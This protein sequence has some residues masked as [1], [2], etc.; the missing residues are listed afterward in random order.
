MK[1]DEALR[2]LELSAESSYSDA[3]KAYKELI[4]VWHSDRYQHSAHLL[5]RAKEKTRLLNEAWEVISAE[6]EEKFDNRRRSKAAAEQ[7]KHPYSPRG[8]SPNRTGPIKL[9]N[10][11]SSGVMMVPIWKN[12]PLLSRR[13]VSVLLCALG[14]LGYGCYRF[15]DLLEEVQ[16]LLSG[17]S[18][19]A[20][21]EQCGAG[22]KGSRLRVIDG[23]LV[24]DL[25]D[26][27]LR[28]TLSKDDK[29]ITA[30]P[31]QIAA[32][33]L[34]SDIEVVRL[35]A[36]ARDLW[37]HVALQLIG[38]GALPLYLLYKIFG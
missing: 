6:G 34:P 14:L 27:A 19:L 10:F 28:L 18:D 26:R 25:P 30:C 11:K 35:G 32:V 31:D 22:G 7:K 21:V 16:L 2:I 5:E 4:Q 38:C 12:R 24:R 20:Q 33:Y 8:G 9:R 23:V 13:R 37:W 36:A 1:I 3:R 29:I 17:K 15:P